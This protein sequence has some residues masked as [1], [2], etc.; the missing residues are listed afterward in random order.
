MLNLDRITNNFDEL[1]KKILA[2]LPPSIWTSTDTKFF[3]PAIGGGQFVGPVEQRLREH[4]HSDENIRSRVFGYEKGELYIRN[5][6]NNYKL[7]GNYKK[8]A[9]EEVFGMNSQIKFDVVLGNPPYQSG[10]KSKGNKQWP[11]FISKA[12]ELT[13]DGGY[14]CMITPTGWASGGQN[15]PGGRG[16]IKDVFKHNQVT[17]INANGITKKYFPEVSMDIGYFVLNKKPVTSPTPI[18][19]P[20]GMVEV[21]FSKVDFI[22]PQLNKI[23]ISIANKVFFGNNET[24]EVSSWD[25]KIKKGKVK[26]SKSETEEFKFKH[27]VLGG[28]TANNYVMTWLNFE[29]G[30]K[31][32]PKVLFNIRNRYWQPYYDLEGINVV[33]QGFDI[34]LTGTEKLEDLKSVFESK[35]FTYISFWY[36]IHMKGFMKTNIAKAYPKLDLMRTW[37]DDQIYE[38]FGINQ[39]ERDKIDTVLGSINHS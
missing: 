36:Q 35:L 21:D 9:Y 18:E 8:I 31:K 26:E 25:H 22:S 7:V 5:A 30:D 20:D 39:E 32:Y 27:W 33:A 1:V 17:Y 37:T 15:I 23:D 4:G 16:I 10:N 2:T 6:V 14:T 12:V 3:D 29:N 13:K 34:R 19:L 38:H 28:T 24:F 11:K